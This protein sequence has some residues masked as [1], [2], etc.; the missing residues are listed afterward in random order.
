MPRTKHNIVDF[1]HHKESRQ[2]ALQCL[3]EEHHVALRTFLLARMAG[4]PDLD[5]IMQDVFV[6]LARVSDLSDRMAGEQ[7]SVRAYILTIANNLLV[8]LSRHKKIQRQ[9]LEAEQPLAEEERV[10][11]AP[12]RIAQGRQQIE[13]IQSAIARLKPM[14]QKAFV[15]SRFKYMSYKEIARQLGVSPRTV[16]DYIGNAL[17]KIRKATAAGSKP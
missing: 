10:D 3:F 2:Q 14:E 11:S 8:D 6:R 12:D 16:E 5:D 7:G 4:S 9:Y 15:L 17:M 1:G 13:I